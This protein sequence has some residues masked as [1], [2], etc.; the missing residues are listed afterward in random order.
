MPN[1][2]G[3]KP[4]FSRSFAVFLALFAMFLRSTI[5]GFCCLFEFLRFVAPFLLF[6][7]FRSA[8]LPK[9]VQNC[10]VSDRGIQNQTCLFPFRPQIADSWRGAAFCCV[11][12]GTH[13][14]P[15]RG[16]RARSLHTKA[17]LQIFGIVPG[18]N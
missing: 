12:W 17:T 7:A 6:G 1:N 11:A 3:R 8:K 2:F 5:P 16:G 9:I 13:T 15:K 14:P 10:P 18:G 4:V